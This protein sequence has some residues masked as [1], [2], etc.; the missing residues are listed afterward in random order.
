MI[1]FTFPIHF[2]NFQKYSI[3][4]LIDFISNLLFMNVNI[5]NLLFILANCY[6][7][8]LFTLYLV[9]NL[10]ELIFHLDLNL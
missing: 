4:Y 3:A 2:C 8:H 10:Q 6:L 7:N 1:C 5:P 9:A